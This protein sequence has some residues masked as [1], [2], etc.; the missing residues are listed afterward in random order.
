[1]AYGMLEAGIGTAMARLHYD[2]GSGSGVACDVWR[3]WA[4]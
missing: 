2:G 1:M 3:G 4:V